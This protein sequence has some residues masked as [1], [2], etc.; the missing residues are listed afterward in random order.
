MPI[1]R[2]GSALDAFRDLEREV[3]RWMKSVDITFENPRL[4]RP[5]PS[6]NLYEI[7]D[8]YLITAELSSCVAS[9]LDLSVANGVVTMRGTRDAS[10]DIPEDR[11]RRSERPSGKWE[12]SISVPERID[13][14]NIRAE[15]TNGL[16]RLYLPK[17]PSAAP[18][19]IHV[20]G[21]NASTSTRINQ[22][23][24]S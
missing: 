20:G 14:D 17:V 2:W 6:L 9:D 15:L 3:D 12:R 24:Q 7:G 11:Y 4:G 18:K 10:G 8:T 21:D 5:F 19:Q 13:D 16:L 1:F 22:E 23:E